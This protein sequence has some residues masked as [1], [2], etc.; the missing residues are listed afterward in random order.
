MDKKIPIDAR[1]IAEILCQVNYSFCL[2]YDAPVKSVDWAYVPEEERRGRAEYILQFM[3]KLMGAN[4][5]VIPTPKEIH[6]EWVKNKK[7]DGWFLGEYD[8]ERKLH[9]NL[10][11]YEEMDIRE[12]IKD[13]LFI[14]GVVSFVSLAKKYNMSISLPE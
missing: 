5:P 6:D 4:N 7:E 10:C 13:Y 14:S 8:L 9:P 11:E 1:D 3:K 12:Q 2:T